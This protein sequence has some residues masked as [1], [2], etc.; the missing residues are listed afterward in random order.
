M[1]KSLEQ[2]EKTIAELELRIGDRMLEVDDI[3]IWLEKYIRSVFSSKSAS[4]KGEDLTL[5]LDAAF[6]IS[7]QL[8]RMIDIAGDGVDD[9][10]AEELLKIKTKYLGS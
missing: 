2:L 4:K 7:I 8:F 9:K 3:F 10:L 6:N 5:P 1:T